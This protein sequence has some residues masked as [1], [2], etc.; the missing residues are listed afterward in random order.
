MSDQK[1]NRA[2]HIHSNMSRHEMPKQLEKKVFYYPKKYKVPKWKNVG[3]KR[4]T[5]FHIHS[6]MSRHEMP[7][8]LKKNLISKKNTKFQNGKM[9]DQ[10]NKAFHSKMS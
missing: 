5:A 8:Q 6:N 9:L 1:K 2:F 7:K 4:N 3:P 10:K